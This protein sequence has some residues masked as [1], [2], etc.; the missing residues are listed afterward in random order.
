YG[1]LL[2][3]PNG[4][5]FAIPLYNKSTEKEPFFLCKRLDF[6]NFMFNYLKNNCTTEIEILQNTTVKKIV[7]T[8]TQAI[9][10][11]TNGDFSANI[12]VAADGANSIAART[13]KQPI[14]KDKNEIIGYR[15]Y[16]KNI[17]NIHNQYYIEI[18]FIKGILPGYFWI[19]PF[20][21]G[22][23]NVGF[24]MFNCMAKKRKI[25]IKQMFETLL[26][27]PTLKERF[28]DAELIETSA[29]GFPLPLAHIGRKLYANRLILTGDAAGLADPL[30]GEGVGN[31]IRSGRFAAEHIKNCIKSNDFSKTFN[32]NYQKA[33]LKSLK[34]EIQI[35]KFIRTLVHPT[36][37]LNLFIKQIV[38]DPKLYTYFIE[39][40]N[41]HKKNK[42]ALIFGFL[43]R[44]VFSYVFK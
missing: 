9:V 8:D 2:F 36:F 32:R 28:T 16:F 20:K 25:H 44:F 19:F 5:N 21:D 39:G 12:V 30:T 29:K 10:T 31:A 43:A 38:R 11:T 18:H 3:A 1:G 37:F 35:F 41:S 6:D 23:A 24:G 33:I 22:T 40:V 4:Y 17:K 34:K 14:S 15:A 27:T 26:Q 42:I 13:I 7:Y